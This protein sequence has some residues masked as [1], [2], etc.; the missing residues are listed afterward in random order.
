[1]DR[2]SS[3]Q[4]RDSIDVSV[5]SY[6][7]ND[8]GIVESRP[9]L[10]FQMKSTSMPE[11]DRDKKVLKYELGIKNYRDLNA[12]SVR[13]PLLAVHVLPPDVSRWVSVA[14]DH[15]AITERML[16]FNVYGSSPSTNPGRKTVTLSI[17][18]KN[19]LT[20]QSLK[21]LLDM[22]AHGETISNDLH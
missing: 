14:D 6:K 21:R 20:T 16:W 11:Y 1:M 8:P 18:L 13:P 12:D 22:V 2:R 4:D 7:R 19:A 9:C 15:L 3:G 5:K 10:D 17:P